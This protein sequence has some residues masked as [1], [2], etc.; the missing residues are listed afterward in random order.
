M[1][2]R[3]LDSVDESQFLNT[4]ISEISVDNKGSGLTLRLV[5]GSERMRY[6]IDFNKKKHLIPVITGDNVPAIIKLYNQETSYDGDSYDNEVKGYVKAMENNI[7]TPRLICFGV[8][9]SGVEYI[10]SEHI[11]GET[12]NETYSFID[13]AIELLENYI[14][15]LEYCMVILTCVTLLLVIIIKFIFVILQDVNQIQ[16]R[17]VYTLKKLMN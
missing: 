13:N 10:V 9:E 8:L 3:I 16:Q 4:L 5:T 1:V 2:D 12:L 17:D 11:P 14:S 15:E 6:N 7:P